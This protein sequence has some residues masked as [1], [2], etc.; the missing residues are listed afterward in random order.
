MFDAWSPREFGEVG[1]HVGLKT[2]EELLHDAWSPD[3]ICQ[4]KLLVSDGGGRSLKHRDIAE[5][6]ERIAIENNILLKQLLKKLEEL[7]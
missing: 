6:S 7:K 3:C 1:D 4:P 2:V 5:S